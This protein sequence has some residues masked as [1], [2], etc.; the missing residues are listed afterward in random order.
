MVAAPPPLPP[1]VVEAP[2]PPPPPP[3]APVAAP[4][5]SDIPPEEKRLHDDA[6]RYARVLAQ[7]ILLYNAQKVEAGRK[8]NNIYDLLK[9]EIDKSREAYE[10]RFKQPQIQGRPYFR[11]ALVQYLCDGNEASLGG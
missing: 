3:P 7:E 1:P 6:R 9:E 10:R 5:A 2:T 4:A 11:D 8:K